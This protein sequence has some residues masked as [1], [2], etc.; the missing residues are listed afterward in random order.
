MKITPSIIQTEFTNLNAKIVKSANR[1]IVGLSGK[2]VD[3]TQK[4]FTIIYNNKRKIV[5]K[6]QTLFHFTL[7][8]E[9]VMEIEGNILLGKPADRIKK[10]IRRLW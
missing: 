8:D 2:V 10:K 6:E 5:P 4:T 1:S 3:E 9:T 7:A